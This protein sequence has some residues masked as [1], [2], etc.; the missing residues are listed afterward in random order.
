MNNQKSLM[1]DFISSNINACNM[2]IIPEGLGDFGLEKSNPIPIYGIDNIEN[3]FS[4][5]RYESISKDGEMLLFPIQYK[6]TIEFDNAQIGSEMQK[7][8]I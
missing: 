5:I 7:S 3:Y 4:S 2:D 1:H 6:R 8:E